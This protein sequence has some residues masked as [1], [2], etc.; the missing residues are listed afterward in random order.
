M[1]IVNERSKTK[2]TKEE[3]KRVSVSVGVDIAKFMCVC[4]CLFCTSSLFCFVSFSFDQQFVLTRHLLHALCRCLTFTSPCFYIPPRSG[5][6]EVFTLC[7]S[8]AA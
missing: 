1:N 6:R 7:R 5:T 4:A 2:K 8:W 3:E